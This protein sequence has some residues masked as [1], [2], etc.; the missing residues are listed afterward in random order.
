MIPHGFEE[1]KGIQYLAVEVSWGSTWV[2]INDGERYVINADVTRQQTSRSW[3]KV[4][5]QSPVLAG[6]YLV[7]A[8]PEMVSEDIGVWVYGIDQTDVAD[9][10]FTLQELFEQ[11]DFRVRWTTNEYR[12]TWRCQLAEV[13]TARGH[14]YTHNMMAAAQFRIPR[15]PDIERER[16]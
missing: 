9:N 5:S 14:V 2:N 3:R 8:V 6:N 4:T 10:L 1:P 15:Y 7:H 16:I 13:S 12:E 11:F